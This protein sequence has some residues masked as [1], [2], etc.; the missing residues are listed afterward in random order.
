MYKKKYAKSQWITTH[1]LLFIPVFHLEQTGTNE[2]FPESQ[3][4][5]NLKTNLEEDHR[6]ISTQEHTFRKLR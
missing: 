6:M 2:V 1:E 5:A 3:I 4:M